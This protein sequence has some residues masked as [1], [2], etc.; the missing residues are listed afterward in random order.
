MDR[1]S[2]H[3]SGYRGRRLDRDRRSRR[4]RAGRRACMFVLA[5]VI[6]GTF[7]A[8]GVMAMA[9]PGAETQ[10][11]RAEAGEVEMRRAEAN[12]AETWRAEANEAE[13]WR[14]EAGGEDAWQTEATV[15]TAAGILLA[16][17]VSDAR[18]LTAKL[19]NEGGTRLS[20]EAGTRTGPPVVA[21]DAGHG[22]EDEG[23]SRDGVMEKDVNLAIAKALEQKL[24]GSGYEVMMVRED[25]TYMTK[26]QRAEKANGADGRQKADIYVSIHQNIWEEPAA[27]GIE[28]WYSEAEGARGSGRLAQLVHQE[29]VRSAGAG[30]R[31]M[32]SDAQFTVTGSTSMPSCLIE[33][34]FLSNPGERARLT[35]E[36][37]QEKLAEGIARGIDLYFNPKTMYLTFDDGPSE[38]NTSAVLDIL[39]ARNIKAT[40]FVVGENVLKHP[41]VARRIA[42]EGHTIGI[43][44][45]RHN[46]EELY[47]S[48]DSY[49]EDFEAAYKAVLEVTGV[50]VKLYRF[51]GGSINAYNSKV[52]KQIIAEMDS[53]GFIY[54]DW[55]ASL[56]DALK[57]SAP[58]ELIANARNSTLGR[59][60]VVLL[61]HDIVHGTSLCLDDLIDQF[62]E[63]RME[64]L[65]PQVE[66]VQFGS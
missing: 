47:R 65:T 51:P 57:K 58:E 36:E 39:K 5:T 9:G 17:A 52:Y 41:E 35:E 3:T 59:K 42:A 27:G 60:H 8:M 23:S 16:Q 44:C 29:T 25:D 45:N 19:S 30:A 32:H 11:R 13:M 22:G 48:A 15:Q 56:D 21:V 37:Y 62:P 63:Y 7:I 49:L 28:T 33:T 12:E 26:E 31:E 54:F 61:A 38:E 46:Y 53:R 55:N 10:M 24:E 14:V 34:G 64:P 20:E 66:T 43:H 6:A 40:F 1:R 50:K 2:N 18:I 4:R